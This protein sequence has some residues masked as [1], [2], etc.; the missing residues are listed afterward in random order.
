[1]P[2]KR[3][4]NCL[5]CDVSSVFI[6]RHCGNV[7]FFA[8]AATD[9]LLR[10][11]S[12][13]FFSKRRSLT[14]FFRLWNR[15]NKKRLRLRTYT[16]AEIMLRVA[17]RTW[18]LLFSYLFLHDSFRLFIFH[19]GNLPVVV[20]DDVLEFEFKWE[21]IQLFQLDDLLSYPQEETGGMSSWVSR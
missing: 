11:E 3:N 19:G 17:S 18:P 5:I 16:F 13:P 7:I 14:I 8:L 9:S 2:I 6:I 12:R 4:W 20:D 1:M 10:F 15:S 21:F